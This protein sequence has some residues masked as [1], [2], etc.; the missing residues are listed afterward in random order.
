MILLLCIDDG[1]DLL[2]P[3]TVFLEDSAHFKVDTAC[4]AAESMIEMKTVHYDSIISYYH[5]AGT[6][7]GMIPDCITR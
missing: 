7:Q 2:D 4:S 1:A 3:V 6:E 5:T